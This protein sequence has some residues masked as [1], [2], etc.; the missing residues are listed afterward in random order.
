MLNSK[1]TLQEDEQQRQ[2][3]SLDDQACDVLKDK[4]SS[5]NVGAICFCST[6]GVTN[7]FTCVQPAK[8]VD[9]TLTTCGGSGKICEVLTKTYG[10]DIQGSTVSVQ[11]QQVEVLYTG[12]HLLSE[13]IEV[14]SKDQCE[15]YMTTLDGNRYQCNDCSILDCPDGKT[16]VDCSN[17]Q[18]DSTTRG[19]C[20]S[21]T[22]STADLGLLNKYCDDPPVV[23]E[24]TT[25]SAVRTASSAAAAGSSLWSTGSNY[26]LWYQNNVVLLATTTTAM[27][28]FSMLMI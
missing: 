5:D 9:E 3:Q 6:G 17:I 1:F 21:L 8:C 24:P 23:V 25:L 11:L 22:T 27:L 28:T 19:Q 7:T 16:N 4:L 15:Y 14:I 2:L 18:A 13:E 26:Y 20:V 10:W 12:G